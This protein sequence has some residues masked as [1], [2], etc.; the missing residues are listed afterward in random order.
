MADNDRPSEMNLATVENEAST[1]I[2]QSPADESLDVGEPE[3]RIDWT[4]S[5]PKSQ[6]AND[7]AAFATQSNPSPPAPKKERRR[8]PRS[9]RP[10]VFVTVTHWA[11]VL[12]LGLSFL[13]G[14]RLTWGYL[15]APFHS[16]SMPFV[17]IAPEGTLLGINLITLHVI[18]SC[19]QGV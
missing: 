16:W 4:A 19:I 15:K 1:A 7:A 11:M 14:I 9:P 18:L 8:E 2:H 6:P 17:P 12:L 3:V 5:E 10:H 13:T